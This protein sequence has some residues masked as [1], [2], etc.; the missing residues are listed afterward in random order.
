MNT[1]RTDSLERLVPSELLQEDST[2]QETLR[3]HLARYQFAA[4]HVSGGR[5]LD[6]ACGVG[7]GSRLLARE[8]PENPVVI[9][10]DIDADAITYAKEF[11]QADRVSFIC[12]DGTTIDGEPFD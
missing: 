5:V 3:L 9:G 7:Y 6:C 8:A 10:V 4:S 2:G 11:Y 1:P 12:A